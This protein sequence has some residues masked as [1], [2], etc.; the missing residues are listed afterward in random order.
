MPE[1]E[2][3]EQEL[4]SINE[5]LDRID[6]FLRGNGQPGVNVRLDRLEIQAQ[7]STWFRRVIA[8]SV[9]GCTVPG[10]IYFVIGIIKGG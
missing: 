7:S 10:A 8:A 9:I 1:V 5:K 3:Y 6:T 4:G 2:H